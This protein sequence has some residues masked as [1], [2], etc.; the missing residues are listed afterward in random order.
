MEG[1]TLAQPRSL[2]DA[3]AAGPQ[4]GA[5]YIAGGTDLM[6][7]AKDNVETPHHLI[8]IEGLL[9][10][11]ISTA[12][13]GSLQLGALARMVEVA[14]HADV[15]SSWPA[16]SEALLLSASPQIRNMGTVGGNLLQR[17]RCGY[18]RD[19][20]FSCNKRSPGSGCPA[21]P[22]ESRGL[23]VLGVSDHCIATHPSDMPVALMAMDASLQL[24]SPGGGTR[25]VPFAEF[26][27]LPGSTPEIETN[28]LPG[29]L[30]V[31]V[32]VPRSASARRSRY[33]KVR[34][35]ASFEFAV[36]SAAVALEVT[37]GTVRNVRI[38]MGGVAP[39]PWRLSQVEAALQGRPATP[40]SFQEA[41]SLAGEGA[42]TTKDNAFKV[43]LMERAILRGL[44]LASA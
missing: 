9:P 40:E 44:Q 43:K 41:A 5:K 1:F 29:E 13:D 3:L 34:D 22:G 36:V 26:Y 24:V 14:T 38:A 23:G 8:D 18:F 21:I 28:L 25:L 16:L 31:A 30:I 37:D 39:R 17:T 19:V 2:D 33:V 7:L 6:Q 20:G 32:V 42:V 27:R 10:D 4:A 11:T 15:R 12:T 35:R